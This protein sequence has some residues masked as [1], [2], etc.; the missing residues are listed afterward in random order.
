[1][2]RYGIKVI[3]E[4]QG[5]GFRFYAKR[6]ADEVGVK[7]FVRNEVDG[8]VSLE[9]QG[10]ES[11]LEEFITWCKHGPSTAHVRDFKVFELSP[12]SDY[13]SFTLCH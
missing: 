13:D 5:V 8:S 6:K 9:A 4:V 3:G 2:K 7:G 11:Q 12:N 10:E 1:M